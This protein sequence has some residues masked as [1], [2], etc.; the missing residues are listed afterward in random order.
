MR[1]R[2]ILVLDVCHMRRRWIHMRRRRI[3]VCHMRPS[4]KPNKYSDFREFV[5]PQ[6]MRFLHA[7]FILLLLI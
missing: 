4:V 3:H 7:G 2:R 6:G 5:P 1:R